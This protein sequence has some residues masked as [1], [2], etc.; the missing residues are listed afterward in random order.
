M[1]TRN[2]QEWQCLHDKKHHIKQKR[3][4]DADFQP[5]TTWTT[6]IHTSAFTALWQSLHHSQ[7][8]Q[9]NSPKQDH[10]DNTC[11]CAYVCVYIYTHTHTH[12]Y[13][14]IGAVHSISTQNAKG[15]KEYSKLL[16]SWSFPQWEKWTQATKQT[17]TTFNTEHPTPITQLKH[18][19]FKSL[20]NRCQAHLRGLKWE[21]GRE[22]GL[23]L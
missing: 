9:S 18:V 21:M 1:F 10:F 14:N 4:K 12:I 15:G 19:G 5:K 23:I 6:G 3:S 20:W 8:F 7:K 11:M 22:A 16:Q 2:I 17:M 13:I